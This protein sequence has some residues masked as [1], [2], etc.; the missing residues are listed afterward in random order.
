MAFSTTGTQYRRSVKPRRR[1]NTFASFVSCAQ[2]RRELDASDILR[3]ENVAAVEFTALH[4]AL[5]PASAKM[6]S[7]SVND[8]EV[9]LLEAYGI[10]DH[11]VLGDLVIVDGEGQRGQ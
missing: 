9:E 8:G 3:P 2:C 5:H 4:P 1:R 10:G 11:L 7:R 6:H